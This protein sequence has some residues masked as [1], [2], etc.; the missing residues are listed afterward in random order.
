M[1]Q[2][3]H[4]VAAGALVIV[5]ALVWLLLAAVAVI[6]TEAA[7]ADAACRR[8]Q[9]PLEPDPAAPSGGYCFAEVLYP[10]AAAVAAGATL[11]AAAILGLCAWLAKT[12]PWVGR[13]VAPALA[14]LLLAVGTRALVDG[15]IGA[16]GI[17]AWSSPTPSI[18][19][20]GALVASSSLPLALGTW[21]AWRRPKAPQGRDGPVLAEDS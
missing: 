17:G 4:A 1:L 7:A 14:F 5:T 19:A 21:L 16:H 15:A 12:R 3:W 8:A 11:L 13:G 6:P 2:P 10:F 9:T 18:V 20:F